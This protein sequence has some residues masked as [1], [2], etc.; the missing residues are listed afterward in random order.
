ML[1]LLPRPSRTSRQDECNTV[2]C[3]ATVVQGGYTSHELSLW[4]E[5]ESLSG[6]CIVYAGALMML[7]MSTAE[8][9]PA[10]TTSSS[11]RLWSLEVYP[12][13]QIDSDES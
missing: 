4:C 8:R 5:R 7:G 10:L 3:N 6:W 12:R 2:A 13:A 1:P 11:A 9:L